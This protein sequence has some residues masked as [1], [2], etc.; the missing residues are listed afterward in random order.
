MGWFG[1]FL[2]ALL[3][4]TVL[5]A[6]GVLVGG[7][8]AGLVRT[9]LERS[10]L[11]PEVRWLVVR[12]VRPTVVVVAVVAAL[13]SLGVDLTAVVALLA[14][15]TLTIGLATVRTL[16]NGPAGAL[17]LTLRPF[18]PGDTVEAAGEHGTVVETTLFAT[19]LKTAEGVL[20][21]L[22]NRLLVEGPIRNHTR[23]GVRRL[24]VDL[25]LSPT[26]DVDAA[27]EAVR[28]ALLDEQRLLPEP[29]PAV[30]VHDDGPDGVGLRAIAWVKVEDAEEVTAEIRRRGRS[31]IR[32]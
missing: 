31:A 25:R 4:A 17:L 16:S 13:E 23:S 2:L 28:R 12:A 3:Y 1:T 27:T 9:A 18:R 14:I 7:W 5:L 19:T 11:D 29:A 10:R 30:H 8:L 22:P 21:T 20:V 32:G 6:A 15:G 26:D 24:E